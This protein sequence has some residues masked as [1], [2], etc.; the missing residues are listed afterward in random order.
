ML[1]EKHDSLPLPLSFGRSCWTRFGIRFLV[2]QRS[3][4]LCFILRREGWNDFQIKMEQQITEDQSAL[5]RKEQYIKQQD[6]TVD[7]LT[8]EK[9]IMKEQ[10]KEMMESKSFLSAELEKYKN[11]LGNLT[12]A[13]A[14]MK[15]T[16]AVTEAS[17]NKEMSEIK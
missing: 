6:I 8:Q 9:K 4:L 7:E 10:L 5:A 2:V 12:A 3:V 11:L 15:K 16:F 1:N 14:D 13:I 17:Y